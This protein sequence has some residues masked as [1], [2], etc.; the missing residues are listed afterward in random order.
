MDLN[1]HWTVKVSNQRVGI[2]V[3]PKSASEPIHRALIIETGVY[4]GPIFVIIS[5]DEASLNPSDWEDIFETAITVPEGRLIIGP[6]DESGLDIAEISTQF[7]GSVRIYSRGRDPYYDQAVVEPTE[8]HCLLFRAEKID[9]SRILKAGSQRGSEMM[10]AAL[11]FEKN[12][13][14]PPALLNYSDEADLSAISL[15]LK[16][17]FGD[18]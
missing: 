14:D 1:G 9:G 6:E 7:T 10:Q 16:K 12:N 13:P 11:G 15:N 5:D 17:T 3:M 8:T 18:E 4:S 2:F